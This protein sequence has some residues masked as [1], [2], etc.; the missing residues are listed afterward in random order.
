[1]PPRPTVSHLFRAFGTHLA[2]LQFLAQPIL[3]FITSSIFLFTSSSSSFLYY[4]SSHCVFF[5]FGIGLALLHYLCHG[6]LCFGSTLSYIVVGIGLALLLKPGQ[7]PQVP[8]SY[9]GETHGAMLR[10][11][12]PLALLARTM[13]D[14]RSAGTS[15]AGSA[16]AIGFSASVPSSYAGE[17]QVAT[18]HSTP[19]QAKDTAMSLAHLTREVAAIDLNSEGA[20]A[21][22]ANLAASYAVGRKEN[23]PAPKLSKLAQRKA[24]AKA[25]PEGLPAPKVPLTYLPLPPAGTMTAAAFVE[26]MTRLGPVFAGDSS[27]MLDP[28]L[29]G[30]DNTDNFVIRRDQAILAIAAYCGYDRYAEFGIQEYNARLRAAREIHGALTPKAFRRG[31]PM[32]TLV[33]LIAGMPDERARKVADIKGRIRLALDTAMDREK[34][35]CASLTLDG[36][37]VPCC[38]QGHFDARVERERAQSYEHDLSQVVG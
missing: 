8:S 10:R 25:E 6:I 9:A 1:M 19:T 29:L 13:C 33:G 21:L 24:E 12:A 2:P 4:I 28:R 3:P 36:S 16:S 18:T 35:A 37:G 20:S 32:P 7:L 27:T 30:Q 22:L 34:A 15:V 26:T 11:P 14:A 17:T 23:E 31:S 38:C 5:L